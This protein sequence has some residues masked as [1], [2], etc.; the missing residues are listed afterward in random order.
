MTKED[1]ILSYKEWLSIQPFS[2]ELH[3]QYD[4]YQRYLLEVS[5]NKRGDILINEQTRKGR[6]LGK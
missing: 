2:L 4:G 3:F 5:N 6:I 1:N